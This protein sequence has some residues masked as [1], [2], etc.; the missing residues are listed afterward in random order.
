MLDTFPGSIQNCFP[1]STEQRIKTRC[2]AQSCCHA[3]KSKDAVSSECVPGLKLVLMR[4]LLRLSIPSTRRQTLLFTQCNDLLLQSQSAEDYSAHLSFH[5]P[6]TLHP[7]LPGLLPC[8]PKDSC[9]STPQPPFIC[10]K[11]QLLRFYDHRTDRFVIQ[12]N[13]WGWDYFLHFDFVV[14]WKHCISRRLLTCLC[15]HTPSPVGGH[16]PSCIFPRCQRC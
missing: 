8:R 14:G 11:K 16:R 3:V 4:P 12:P 13:R 7:F 1:I 5:N 10:R 6:S 15:F 2:F 9:S